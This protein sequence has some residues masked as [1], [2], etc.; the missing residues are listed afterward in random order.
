MQTSQPLQGMRVA[1][2]PGAGHRALPRAAPVRGWQQKHK[3]AQGQNGAVMGVQ[4]QHDRRLHPRGVR[5]CGGGGAFGR[6]AFLPLE[7]N[8]SLKVAGYL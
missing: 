3:D 7:A 1:P 4:G 8:E 5:G 6:K 2:L